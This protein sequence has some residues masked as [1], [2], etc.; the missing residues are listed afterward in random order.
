MWPFNARKRFRCA[1]EKKEQCR[2]TG[3]TP[4]FY[5][6]F[7]SFFEEILSLRRYVNEQLENVKKS[8]YDSKQSAMRS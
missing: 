5:Y 6:P 2:S 4:A 3:F 1:R 7:W 8:Q